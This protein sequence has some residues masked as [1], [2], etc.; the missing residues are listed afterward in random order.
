MSLTM[1]FVLFGGSFL[2]HI[3]YCIRAVFNSVTN[4][5]ATQLGVSFSVTT[6]SIIEAMQQTLFTHC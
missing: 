1:R 3:P 6:D 5:C 2:M 4:G